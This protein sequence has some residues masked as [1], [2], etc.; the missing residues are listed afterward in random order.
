MKLTINFSGLDQ[1]LT[2]MGAQ[3]RPFELAAHA[4]KEQSWGE[5]DLELNK[6]I[7]LK[8]IHTGPHKILHINNRPIM[9]YIPDHSFNFEQTVR[10]PSVG[11]KVHFAE[12][13]TITNMRYKGFGERYTITEK[14]KGLFNIYRSNRY[15]INDKGD[16]QAKLMPCQNCLRTTG[17]HDFTYKS[18]S[19]KIKFLQ[20]F[21]YV[22][23]FT[24]YRAFF[25]KLPTKKTQADYDY[26][27]DF[28]QISEAVKQR[29]RFTCAECHVNLA[30]DKTLLHTHH[31]DRMKSN[32]ALSNLV[33]LCIECH[34]KQPYHQHM[35]LNSN[36]TNRLARLRMQ[37]GR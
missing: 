24:H 16:H 30:N 3:E 23:L 12:C 28:M 9:L 2:K 33:C 36:Q 20:A 35:K 29:A 25:K 31:I 32:N 21:S 17:Y 15:N 8:D 5:L 26:T 14:T 18:Q 10:N 4:T 34:A 13:T 7:Q 19:E 6:D 37:Q 22:D 1:A 27:N 11:K